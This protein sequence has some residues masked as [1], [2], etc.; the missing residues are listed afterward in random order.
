MHGVVSKRD[1]LPQLIHA[2][3]VVAGGSRHLSPIAQAALDEA[4][5]T[6]QYQFLTS[7][8][9]RELQTLGLFAA[10]LSVSAAARLIGRSVKTVS[11]QK[12]AVK[13]KIA[14]R[15]DWDLYVHIAQQGL[16]MRPAI[17]AQSPCSIA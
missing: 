7:L 6:P 14:A 12:A 2:I 13:R 16:L 5:A 9:H 17:Q 4:A 3:E 10:G 1:P 8:T 15:S 11:A